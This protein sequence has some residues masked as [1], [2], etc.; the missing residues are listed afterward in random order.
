MPA[1]AAR[2]SGLAVCGM[3][4]GVREGG[5]VSACGL[6]CA[7]GG[8]ASAGGFAWAV[9]TGCEGGAAALDLSAAA[10]AGLGFAFACA[11]AFGV[12]LAGG[13]SSGAEGTFSWVTCAISPALA[14][15]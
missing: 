9:S 12:A 2:G 8:L 1:P 4:S 5:M 15:G 3:R 14:F 13:A 10:G 7:A 6:A 11:P